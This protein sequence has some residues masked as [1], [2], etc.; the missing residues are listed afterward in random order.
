[1][2]HNFVKRKLGCCVSNFAYGKL[3]G[4]Y[5]L[6]ELGMSEFRL[7]HYTSV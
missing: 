6:S 4:Y 3:R 7:P 1:M 2:L 5:T